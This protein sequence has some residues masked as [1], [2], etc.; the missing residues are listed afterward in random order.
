MRDHDQESKLLTNVGRVRCRSLG[1]AGAGGYMARAGQAPDGAVNA[2]PLPAPTAGAPN[3]FADI[4][5]HVAP[6]V[7][8]IE[9]EGK[10]GPQR[11]A[12]SEGDFRR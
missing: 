9:V 8:S 6:A 11:I 10:L 1:L 4:I 3:S 12:D 2:R 5:Q 7:V